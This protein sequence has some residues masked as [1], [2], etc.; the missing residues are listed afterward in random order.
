MYLDTTVIIVTFKS[1]T[2]IFECLKNINHFKQ[3]FILDNS[4]DAN[5]EIKIKSQYPNIF[6]FKSKYNLGYSR[7]HNFLLKMVKTKYALLISPDV[8]FDFEEFSKI[9]YADRF[10]NGDY[11]VLAP[12]DPN[13]LKKNYGFN[14]R[15][16]KS[17]N[18]SI[19]SVDYVHGFFMFMNVMKIKSVG[20][21]DKNFFLYNEDIDLCNRIKLSNEKIY[22]I[23]NLKVSHISSASSDI[24]NEY[25][26]C[27]DWHWMWS[28]FYLYKKNKGYFYAFLNYLPILLKLLL[29]LLFFFFISNKL[30]LKNLMR[31]KGLLNSMLLKKSFYR[32]KI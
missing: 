28:K 7:G 17:V 18:Q 15:I 26:K 9:H 13:S 24:G 27:K 8:I 31:F 11:A 21:F 19:Y 23:K 14:S 16:A 5:L 10:L 32:P 3:I 29:K 25:Y 22:I 12:Y 2:V 4:N 20:F 30:Y 1:E 6:F